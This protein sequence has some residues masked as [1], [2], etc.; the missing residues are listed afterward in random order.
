MK[1]IPVDILAKNFQ[2]PVSTFANLTHD[3]MYI[4]A[5]Q[6][7]RA[8]E[9]EKKQAANG[10]GYVKSPYAYFASSMAPTVTTTGGLVKVV[11]QRNFPV[12]TMSSAIVTL[13]PG[14]LRELHWHPNGDEWNYF[15]KGRARMGVF[16]AGGKARTMNFEEGD[17]GYIEK[18][19][20]HYIE[21]IGDTDVVFVEVFATPHF[22]DVSLAQWLA[23][24]PTRLVDEHLHLG[25]KF[26]ESISK[27][28]RTLRP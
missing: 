25:E 28:E 11:D 7:P 22:H 16:A 12:A 3:E 14:A 9:D 2:V 27:D 19:L 13:K 17:V 15:V 26:L 4:F 8:L 20:P 6:L 10:T 5:S 23:H 21:N 18:D 24:T 1:H